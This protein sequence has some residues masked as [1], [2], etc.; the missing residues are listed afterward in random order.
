MV[1][2]QQIL[3]GPAARVFA[4]LA[5]GFLAMRLLDAPPR[6]V[7]ELAAFAGRAWVVVLVRPLVVA[8]GLTAA[9][10]ATRARVNP[11]RFRSGPR[12]A[13]ALAVVLA[14][15]LLGSMA[16][17]PAAAVVGVVFDLTV[18]AAAALLAYP[19]RGRPTRVRRAA[20]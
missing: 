19:D 9:L 4:L 2:V 1:S 10:Y 16:F 3:R 17:Q 11:A 13:T 18:G 14:T 6:S 7:A 12:T 15:Q 20:T 8:L 5:V